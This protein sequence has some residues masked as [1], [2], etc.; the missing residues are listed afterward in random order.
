MSTSDVKS[1]TALLSS[2]G[3]D[4]LGHIKPSICLLGS[5][6]THWNPIN[7]WLNQ[8]KKGNFDTLHLYALDHISCPA[9]AT[10]CERAL[11][12]PGRPDAGEKCRRNEGYRS[13]RMSMVVV[14]ERGGLGYANSVSYDAPSY[15]RGPICY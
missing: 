7:W 12:Q 13:M 10:Q 6:S 11:V 8:S 4:L 9:M 5:P 15:G 1:G 14:E 3:S 2:S